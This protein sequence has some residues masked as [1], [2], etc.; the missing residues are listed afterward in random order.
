MNTTLKDALIGAL[1]FGAMSYCSQKYINNPNYFK[2]VA[3]AWSAPFTYFYLLYITSRSG[4]KPVNDFNRHALI[5]ILFTAFLIILYMFL[6]D[7]FYIDDLITKI[8]YLTALF[9]IGYFYF[10]TFEKI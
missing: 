3:F 2:I 5:G 1:M 9:T 4:V 8:F 10:K 7:T 6:K